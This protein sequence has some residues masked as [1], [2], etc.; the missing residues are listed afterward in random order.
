MN[1]K[2]VKKE[3]LKNSSF[4]EEYFRPN[5]GL[6]IS[7]IRQ[8][9]RLTQKELANKVRTKQTGIARIESDRYLPSLLLIHRIARALGYIVNISFIKEKDFMKGL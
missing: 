9:S 3:L 8:R 2:D 1:L 5:V 4:R 6:Q 7:V